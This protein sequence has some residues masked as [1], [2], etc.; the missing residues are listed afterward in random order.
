MF[1][2][3]AALCFKFKKIHLM[4]G[5]AQKVPDLAQVRSLRGALGQDMLLTATR[6]SP[7]KDYLMQKIRTHDQELQTK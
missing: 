7:L 6:N 1:T 3:G 2:L 4:V 5:M